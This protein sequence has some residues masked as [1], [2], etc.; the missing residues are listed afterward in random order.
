MIDL[1]PKAG[2][3]NYLMIALG[4]V[5]L[6]AAA[7]GTEKIPGWIYLVFAAVALLIMLWP[8]SNRKG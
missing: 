2:I 3:R 4:L 8:R 6:L 7:I 5:A 1:Q